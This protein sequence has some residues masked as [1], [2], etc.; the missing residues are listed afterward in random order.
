MGWIKPK[1]NWTENDY[2]NI[3]DYDRITGN[4][5]YLKEFLDSLFYG[6]TDI[7]LMD[8]KMISDPIYAREINAIESNIE[9]LNLETYRLN[10]GETKEYYPNQ[11]TID[12]NELN[13]IESA[14][15][16]IYIKMINQKSL[17]TRLSFR[18]G[19]QKGLK[20]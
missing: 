8:E 9:L 17:L 12:F 6:L 13:R 15:M 2:F 19:N 20:V 3:E 11:R 14:I 1:T 10:I 16:N 18:I 5:T 7:Q 4:V